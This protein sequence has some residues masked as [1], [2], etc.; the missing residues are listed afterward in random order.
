MSS[1]EEFNAWDI[2]ESGPADAAHRVLLLPGGLCSAAF[3]DDMVAE[4]AL[5]TAPVRLVAATVPGMA[6]TPAP[7][8]LSMENY[9]ALAGAF[10]AERGCGVVVGHS[11]GAN[12]ALEMAAGGHFAGRIVL[13]SPTFSR[14][15][16]SKVLAVVD[17][18]GRLPGIGALAWSAMVWVAPRALSGMLPPPRRE[19]LVAEL[20]KNDAA[21]CRRSVRHYFDYLDHHG[22]LVPRLRDSGVQAWVVRGDRDEIGLTDDERAALEASPGVT[23]V[24]IPDATHMVM[25]DQP[26]RVAELVAQVVLG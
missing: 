6:G 23:M 4:P 16:E 9:A 1:A 21:Y 20:K 19:A 11:F 26:A 3:Y 24:T 5:A 25:T 17:R 7:Q 15:D 14:P 10:A 22:S 13:L 2:R 8:N 12:I 18:L